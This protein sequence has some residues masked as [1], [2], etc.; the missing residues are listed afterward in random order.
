MGRNPVSKGLLAGSIPAR[1]AERVLRPTRS[2]EASSDHPYRSPYCAV[3]AK[4]KR[5]AQTLHRADVCTT[6][7]LV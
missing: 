5:H 1:T 2:D 7:G 3:T 4:R 6:G